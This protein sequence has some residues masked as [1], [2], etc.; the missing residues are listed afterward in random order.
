MLHLKLPT[1]PQW[2][3]MVERGNLEEILTDHA[4]CEQKAAS[5]CI[6]IIQSYP[7][8][9]KVVEVLTPVVIEEWQHFARVHA[10]LKK[11]GLKLGMQRKDAYVN[12]LLK[13]KRKGASRK[14]S[15]IDKLLIC[16]LIE[17][18]SCERFKLLWQ[19]LKDEELKSF[20]YDLMVSEAGHY[21]N[22]IELA[23]E[24]GGRAQVDKRWQELLYYEIDVL[25]KIP[26]THNKIH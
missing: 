1:E 14:E 9:E 11:R 15:L 24:I 10:E 2:V 12:E 17:A 20:Y 19:G 7:D 13:W 26:P 21:V 18:R 25:Q 6:S 5:S 3:E 8:F 16:A 4:Y 23:R 22:F